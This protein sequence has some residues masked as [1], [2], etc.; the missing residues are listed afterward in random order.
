MRHMLACLSWTA[1]ST[2][3]S[4]AKTMDCQFSFV[5]LADPH[6]STFPDPKART[7][8]TGPLA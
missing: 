6:I 3:D 8:L 7:P 2:V 5:V 1:D 4:S